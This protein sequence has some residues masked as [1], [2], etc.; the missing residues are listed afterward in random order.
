VSVTIKLFVNMPVK[1]VLDGFPTT[2]DEDLAMQ[3]PDSEFGPW[4]LALGSRVSFSEK[5]VH[6]GYRWF[7]GSRRVML[8]IVPYSHLH[9][10]V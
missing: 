9:H 6:C 5:A 4:R 3:H 2:M 1:K 10:I 8:A 7:R